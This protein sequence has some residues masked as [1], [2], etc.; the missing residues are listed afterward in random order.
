M[1]RTA[2]AITK[3]NND[4]YSGGPIFAPK[5]TSDSETA[6]LGNAYP[7]K[8]IFSMIFVRAPGRLTDRY[9]TGKAKT[10]TSTAVSVER[11]IELN[12]NM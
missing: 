11:V 4:W 10:T 5:N 7:V 9:A 6:I 2:Q 12:A 1:Y 3:S 8:H